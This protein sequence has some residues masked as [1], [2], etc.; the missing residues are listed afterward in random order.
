[1]SSSSLAPTSGWSWALVVYVVWSIV[2]G[3]LVVVMA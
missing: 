2:V 1:M 3:W